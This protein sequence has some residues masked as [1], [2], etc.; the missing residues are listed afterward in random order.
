MMRRWLIPWS[1]IVW[2]TTFNHF[3]WGIELLFDDRTSMI[4]S[5]ATSHLYLCRNHIGNAA[6]LLSV[7]ALA[8]FGIRTRRSFLGLLSAIPQQF[9]LFLSAF[10]ACHGVWLSAF[11]DGVIRSRL[12]ILADQQIHILIAFAHLVGILALHNSKILHHG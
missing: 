10:G 2:L 8:A 5:I 9:L 1:L 4:T 6:I 12:F 3:A 7:S 11:A